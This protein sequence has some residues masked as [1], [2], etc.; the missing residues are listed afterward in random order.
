MMRAICRAMALAALSWST[1]CSD[2]GTPSGRGSVIHYPEILIVNDHSRFL[3]LGNMTETDTSEVMNLVDAYYAGSTVLANNQA[4]PLLVGQST[5]VTADEAFLQSAVVAGTGLLNF[6]TALPGFAT[7]QM[8]LAGSLEHDVAIL[9]TH[10]PS[11]LSSIVLV[12]YVGTAC[13]PSLSAAIVNVSHSSKSFN[14][15]LVAHALGHLLGMCHDPPGDRSKCAPLPST[16]AYTADA[17]A[18]R[19]MAVASNPVAPSSEFSTCSAHDFDDYVTNQLPSP[20]C[21]VPPTAGPVVI[22]N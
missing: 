21:L 3:A 6:E 10:R 7:Y 13:V 14:A 1:G 22:V 2:A 5:M 16:A 12:S 8:G 15:S 19:I 9:L 17:C 20:N 11:V 18:N 4:R